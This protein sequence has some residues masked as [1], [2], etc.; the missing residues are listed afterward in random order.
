MPLNLHRIFSGIPEK[1]YL[2]ALTVEK[3]KEDSLRSA[4]DEIRGAL[5]SALGNLT[6]FPREQLFEVLAQDS[7]P[8]SLKPKFRMQGS[9]SYRTC[10]DPAHKPPQQVDLDDGMFLPVSFLQEKSGRAHPTIVSK[11]LFAAVEQALAPLCK[12]HG[13]QLVDKPSC[14]RIELNDDAH[15]DVALYAIPDNAYRTL[16][17]KAVMAESALARDSA[18]KELTDATELSSNFYQ[19]LFQTK[20]LT[21][22]L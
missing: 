8:T 6:Q 9:F 21:L 14:V 1:D 19:A 3:R 12:K 18:R 16:V 20:L 2:S 10:N 15:I 22:F 11:G 13:W 7:V 17:E 5:R 4:R